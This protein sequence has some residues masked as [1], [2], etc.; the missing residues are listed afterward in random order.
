MLNAIKNPALVIIDMQNDFVRTGA[1]MEVPAARALLPRLETLLSKVRAARLPVIF[2][3]YV[4]TPGYEH[5]SGHLGWLKLIDP[6][7]RACVPG[8]CR[9]YED[10][11][12]SRDG[13][14]IVDELAPEP[15]EVMIEKPFFSAFHG[16]DL[17]QRLQALGTDGL[18]VT[19]TITEMC[20]EDTARHAVHHGYRTVIASDLVASNDPEMHDATLV[21]FARNFGQ[22]ASA[23]VI[24]SQIQHLAEGI[25]D[26]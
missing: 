19:G 10:L 9:Y 20:V 23:E 22:V 25:F 2:T 13:A 11:R 24:L 15:T 14:D 7:V 3:R 17:N 12:S 21:A 16:T 1:P 4:A 18:I 8:V 6:P 26:V 5:L